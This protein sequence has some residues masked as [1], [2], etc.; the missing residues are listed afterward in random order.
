MA[1][2]SPYRLDSQ[3]IA[4]GG[5]AVVYR[6]T[7]RETGQV[8]AVKRNLVQDAESVD[9]LRREI[10]VQRAM[11]HPNIMPILDYDPKYEWYTMPLAVQ[12][13]D[14]LIRPV[15][16]EIL[17]EIVRSCASALQYAH[18]MKHLHRDISHRNILQLPGPSRP[19]WVLSDWGLVRRLGYTTVVR[20]QPGQAIGTEAFA[21]PEMFRD[22]HNAT[23][24]TDVYSLGRVVAWCL[25]EDLVPNIPVHVTGKWREFIGFTTNLDSA[26]RVPDMDGVLR[27]L[28][29]VLQPGTH[30]VYSENTFEGAQALSFYGYFRTIVELM[31]N[32][33]NPR[34]V[35]TQEI[36][37]RIGPGAYANHRKL[38]LGPW[39]LVADGN[40]RY[41]RR[42]TGKGI[43]FVQGQA[44]VPKKIVKNPVTEQWVAA[45]GTKMIL[46]TEVGRDQ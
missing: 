42:L 24:A 38:S 22:A 40:G 10:Q 31:W 7:H 32:N 3:P 17:I 43:R 18:G 37:E 39:D 13:L 19:R 26:K 34:E 27:L 2:Q 5:W 20:T 36:R 33:G 21:A 35:P 16:E 45:P 25:G 29:N 46:I 14:N 6:A 15:A 23:A 44:R 11:N 30:D 28:D 1:Q 12:V 4:R 9:R 8:V 41:T